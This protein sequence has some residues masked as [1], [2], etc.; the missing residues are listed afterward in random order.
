MIDTLNTETSSSTNLEDGIP[1]EML[2][3]TA[4]T[5]QDW[6]KA[7]QSDRNLQFVIDRLIEGQRPT[8]EQLKAQSIAKRNLFDWDKYSLKESV[9]HRTTILNGEKCD[10]LVLPAPMKDTILRVYNEDLGH[11]GR[12]RTTSLLKR[13]F[14]WPGMNKYIRHVVDA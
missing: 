13:R 7:Q 2:K 10:Q 6:S 3:E 12:D 4:L 11:Q 14:F 1:E 8:V 5:S 9:L